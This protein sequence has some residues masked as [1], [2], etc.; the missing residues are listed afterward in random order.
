[1]KLVG[2]VFQGGSKPGDFSWMI[3][4]PEYSDALFIFNDNEQE[5]YLHRQQHAP[6]SD[7]C[8]PGGGNATIRPY[9]CRLP[10]RATGVPTG[11]NGVGYSQLNKH[12]RG[13]I[14]EAL[15][16]IADLVA[17][18]QVATVI[19]SADQAGGLGT[20]IFK[21]GPDVRGYIVDGLR[22]VATEGMG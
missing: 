10:Q 13:V 14:D 7:R 19:Y 1:M 2:S 17:G 16:T 20:G 9:Q 12:V 11:S 22:R 4:Q 8:S 3:E 6:G 15:G 18:G 21:V 5:F